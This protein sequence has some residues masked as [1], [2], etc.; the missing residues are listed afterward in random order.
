MEAF[1]WFHQHPELS[2]EEFETTARIREYLEEAGIEILPAELETGL[3]AVIRGAQ[4]GPI[5]ALR[6]D[7]DAL[8]ITEETDLPYRSVYP[9][10][11][12]RDRYNPMDRF[13]QGKRH[14]KVQKM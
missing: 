5:Q 12:I 8:P 13:C 3:A 1:C 2:Y 9:E 4:E 11:C 10:M 6:C 7:I 14:R